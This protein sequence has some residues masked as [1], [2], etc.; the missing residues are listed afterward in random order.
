MFEKASDTEEKM[1]TEF[2]SKDASKMRD[3]A[4]D[5]RKI[6]IELKKMREQRSYVGDEMLPFE[7]SYVLDIE[8]FF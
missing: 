1:Q 5:W 3:F 6:M 8:M 4:I 7:K 2:N